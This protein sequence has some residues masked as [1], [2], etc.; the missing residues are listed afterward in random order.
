MYMPLMIENALFAPCGMDC[1]VCSVH[2]KKK[3]PCSGCLSD[4]AG[5][6]ERCKDCKIKLCAQA[7][8]ISYCFACADFPCQGIHNLEK[9]YKKRDHLSLL[10]NSQVVKD[11]GLEFFL[12]SEKNKWS[13]ADCQGV[14]SLHDK[15]CSECG[16]KIE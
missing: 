11:K 12:Q 8:G 5:K 1:L 13:C 15:T 4:D 3:K 14:I 7:K 2:L 16:K 9:S 10:E 6:P